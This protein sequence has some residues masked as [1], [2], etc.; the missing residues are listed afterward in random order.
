MIKNLMLTAAFAFVAGS[1]GAVTLNSSSSLG[2]T[3]YLNN[4]NG[5][6]TYYQSWTGANQ[7]SDGSSTFW[8]YCIDPKTNTAWGSNVYTT[9]S[10]NSF[11]NTPYGASNTSGYAQQM[12]SGGY[13][14]LSYGIQNAAL[15][16]SKLTTLF[17]HAYADSLSD[18]SGVKAAAFGFT[19]WEIMG[20][21]SY[22][23]TGGA[24]R[25]IGSYPNGGDALQTQIDAY[26]TALN[27]NSWGNVRGVNLS[28]ARNYTYTVYF[29]PAPHSAQ[30]FLRAT[31][32]PEPGSLALAGLA[33]AGVF[34]MRR[35]S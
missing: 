28:S 2:S 8:A 23:R 35:K 30:N 22:S 16:E 26:I 27:T 25:S 1:A 31:A 33:L 5:G 32:V 18:P 21:S 11:L 14:N 3:N 17:S 7:I 4:F 34:W 10:L 6:S 13:N 19:V 29:D 20:Q 12:A 24:L 15:V 9:A